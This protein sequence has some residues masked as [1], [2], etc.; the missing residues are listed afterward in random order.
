MG[1]KQAN[2][3]NIIYNLSYHNHSS[4]NQASERTL[5]DKGSWK[6]FYWIYSSLY[7][8]GITDFF[9][10]SVERIMYKKPTFYTYGSVPN[11]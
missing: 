11:H 10:L 5:I 9:R 8:F 1:L 7:V 6:F 2:A 3:I 4:R